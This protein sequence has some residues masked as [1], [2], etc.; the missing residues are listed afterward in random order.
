MA[1]SLRGFDYESDDGE[2]YRIFRD[3]SNTEALN[4]NA[5]APTATA[6]LPRGYEPRYALLYQVS[7]PQVKRKVTIL[8]T[9]DFA[10]ILGGTDYSLAV[11]GAT[12]QNFRV[13]ALIGERRTGLVSTDT[14]QDDGD[15]PG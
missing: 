3:E 5:G 2:I 12:A 1:G 4:D 6:S 7:N 10:D 14:G 9:A 8:T 15:T 13:S 11:V